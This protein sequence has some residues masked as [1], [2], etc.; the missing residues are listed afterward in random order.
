MN[1]P[2]Q[3]ERSELRESIKQVRSNNRSLASF[4]T[5]GAIDEL[6]RLVLA[7]TAERVAETEKAYGGCQLC[8]G[9][10][11][12]TY[13]GMYYAHGMQWPDPESMKFC[14]CERGKQLEKLMGKQVAGVR[15][16][17]LGRANTPSWY[18]KDR[19]AELQ[20]TR[21]ATKPTEADKRERSSAELIEMYE[22]CI[23][24]IPPE[25][26]K[27]STGMREIKAMYESKIKE[28]KAQAATKEPHVFNMAEVA[29]CKSCN[30]MRH[31][32]ADGL[33]GRCVGAATK[34]GEEV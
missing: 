30:A 28:L 31:L 10:G 22:Y 5:T 14:T 20:R 15:I 11:Y 8:F 24:I 16:D 9:K 6:E 13:Q 1:T 2:Q 29:V 32:D 19:I 3:P 21:A 18:F 27:K 7:Y 26:G 23:S 17:E 34:D 12:A 4:L 25:L 33:C